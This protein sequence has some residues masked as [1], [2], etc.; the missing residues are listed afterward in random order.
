MSKSEKEQAMSK[1]S[2]RYV[3]A[4]TGETVEATT[5]TPWPSGWEGTSGEGGRAMRKLHLAIRVVEML[6]A[7]MGDAAMCE[8]GDVLVIAAHAMI[9]DPDYRSSV[10]SGFTK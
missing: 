8:G 5:T 9:S 6:H 3:S 4:T 10:L 2:L 1:N 7:E